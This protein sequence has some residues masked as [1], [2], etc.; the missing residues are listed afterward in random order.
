M[1]EMKTYRD[2]YADIKHQPAMSGPH[3]RPHTK[4][5][6]GMAVLLLILIGIVTWALFTS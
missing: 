2:P 4:K 3:R 1:K 6:I 5:Y